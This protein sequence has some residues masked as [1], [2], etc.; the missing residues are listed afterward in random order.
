MKGTPTFRIAIVGLTLLICC[1]P[2]QGA[3]AAEDHAFPEKN[4]KFE[5]L[6]SSDG[7]AHPFVFDI[8]QDS[9]GFLWFGTAEGLNRYDGYEFI[10][11][12]PDPGNF[13]SLSDGYVTAILEDE[14]GRLWLGTSNGLNMFDPAAETFT[15]YRHKEEDP[16]SL[17]HNSIPYN[18][19]Y[20]DRNGIVWI[21]TE[22]GGLN[23]FDPETGTF[24]RYQHD[25]HDMNSLSED[26]VFSITSAS[27]H[28]E[29][30]ELW[31]GTENGLNRFDPVSETFIRYVHDEHNPASLSDNRIYALYVPPGEPEHIVWIG[32]AGGLN[33]LD[34][35]NQ[36]FIHYQHNESTPHSLSHDM[37]YD[38]H[39]AGD[40]TLWIATH[41]GGLNRFDP[42]SETFVHYRHDPDNPQSL[43]SD[44]LSMI[45]QDQAGAL[46]IGTHGAGVT[47]FDPQNQKFRHYQHQ[48][49]TP[50]SLSHSAVFSITVDEQGL[51]WLG[52][53]GGL[54]K[55]DPNTRTFTSYQHDE[56]NPTSLS[57]NFAHNV[58]IDRQG[59]LWVGTWGGGLNRFDRKTETFDLF[60]HQDFI[61]NRS[62][63]LYEDRFGILWVGTFQNGVYGLDLERN[64]LVNYRHDEDDPYS[65]SHNEVIAIFEDRNGTLWFG[66]HGGLN[67]FDRDTKQCIRYTHDDND[68][69]SLSNNHVKRVYEDS[70]GDLWVTTNLGL[71]RFDRRTKRFTVYLEKDGLPHNRVNS[72]IEDEQGYL[73]LGTAK[74]LSRF[75]PR[76]NTYKNYDSR[77]GL[78]SDLFFL[79]SSAKGLNGELYFG[80]PHGLNV[81]HPATLK[82][83]P[84]VPPVVLTEFRMVNTP[85]SPAKD[86][87]LPQHLYA[88][89]KLV[90][91]YDQSAFGFEFSALNYTIPEKNQYAYMM[92]GFEQDWIDT[93]SQYRLARYTNLAPGNYRFRVK[94]SNNDGVWNEYGTSVNI[95]ILPPWWHTWWFHNLLVILLVGGAAGGYYWRIHALEARSRLL[96]HQVAER[97]RELVIAKE[98]AE[99]ANQA[100]STFLANMSH[101]LRSPLNAIIGFAQVLHQSD[102]LSRQDHEH[103]GIIRRSGEHLLTLINQ[104]LDLSKIEAGRMTCDANN[105]DL[106]RLLHDV[107]D[108]FALKAEK[109]RLYLLFEQDEHVPRYVRTDEVKLRQVLINLLNNAIKFTEEG[110]VAVRIDKLSDI[111]DM[112]DVSDRPE[113]TRLC[114]EIEDTG[115]GIAPEEL[116]TVFE[117]FGQTETGRQSQEGAGLG[118]PISRKFVQLMGGD[119]QVNS[120][121]GHGT[122]FTFDIQAQVVNEAEIM[123]Q[124]SSRRRVI[125]LEPGQPRYRILV[126]DDRQTNR[127]LV[128]KLL[129]PFG[130]E[131]REAANGQE[132][133]EFW[134][135]WKPHLIWMDMRMPVLDGYDATKRI[136]RAEERKSANT[137]TPTPHTAIIAITASSLEEDR[138]VVMN[139]GCDD[140]LRKPFREAELFALMSKHLGV[141]FV[142]EEG[143]RAIRETR[144]TTLEEMLGPEAL[145]ALPGEWL[146]T[147]AQGSQEANPELLYGVIEQI[148]RRD[149]ALANALTRVVDD[150]EY[151]RILQSIHHACEQEAT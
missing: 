37:V 80:G 8:F 27:P 89:D 23:K 21:G 112:P 101:E 72:I 105:F 126:V 144:H 77:D 65:L 1:G 52:T 125:A 76:A 55:F 128:V 36:T 3:S 137:E 122:V 2:A 94:A 96:E 82:K 111:S 22:G 33:M 20:L 106:H 63:S 24:T 109:K 61:I 113:Q 35:E 136:R 54:N 42:A 64:T 142:Y 123:P 66:T 17:S 130:F 131:L 75:D 99:V 107:Q 91:S 97:T 67:A 150:F 10:V 93:S 100:K 116:D 98:Q 151:G 50:G 31:I 41:G 9:Q 141:K 88:M 13:N 83:N 39:P 133:I 43:S 57:H 104:V 38:I 71:N 132:A 4:L 30:E 102:T 79:H 81:F 110:G 148:R 119:M 28:G 134:E 146:T 84:Y 15:H 49:N 44:I 51:V 120:E 34:V 25:D 135:T 26:H 59:V 140:Y 40:G 68:P 7:L 124:L 45:C 18:A 95:T 149:T 69:S 92:E 73:W 118:L 117:A 62:M 108:M 87:F 53:V 86:S 115:S 127:Q 6:S 78:Q 58:Y 114:F 60:T 138:A 90:L 139:A 11:Y 145:A 103:L 56:Q 46:W 32:T 143:T 129:Q 48:A 47:R 121:L 74:G 85:L 12:K 29:T 5:H 147:L 70:R 19:V 16:N 14:K